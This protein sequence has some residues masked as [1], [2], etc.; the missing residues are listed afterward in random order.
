MLDLNTIAYI[1]MSDF[2]TQELGAVTRG[3]IYRASGESRARHSRGSVF[4]FDNG[5]SA[6]GLYGIPEV[7]S[8]NHLTN[9]RLLHT[10]EGV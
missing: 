4:A 8:H 2:S 5:V 9:Y 6:F 7:S 3:S 1:A 10:N